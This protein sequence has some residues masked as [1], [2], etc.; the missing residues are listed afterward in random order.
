MTVYDVVDYLASGMT[1]PEILADF[2]D[3]TAEDLRACLAFA[4]AETQALIHPGVK[5]L[6]DENL[7]PAQVTILSEMYLETCPRPGF[8]S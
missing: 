3:V 5:L 7:S 4:A 8:R 1:E 2:P 6:L